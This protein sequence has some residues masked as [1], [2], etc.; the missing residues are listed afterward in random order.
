LAHAP[1]SHPVLSFVVAP[2]KGKKGLKLWHRDG[3]P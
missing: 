2:E 3:F 1:F